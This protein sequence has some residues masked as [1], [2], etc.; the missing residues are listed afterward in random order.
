MPMHI[1]K[2]ALKAMDV[3]LPRRFPRHAATERRTASK[4]S[5]LSVGGARI[6]DSQIAAHLLGGSAHRGRCSRYACPNS[7]LKPAS[8]PLNLSLSQ[9]PTPGTV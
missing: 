6:V 5:S 2:G 9:R 7:L 1:E 8:L 4:P 3:E